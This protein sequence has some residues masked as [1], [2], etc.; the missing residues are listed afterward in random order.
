MSFVVQTDE[1]VF[2]KITEKTERSI[3]LT[4]C[5]HGDLVDVKNSHY[6]SENYLFSLLLEFTEHVEIDNKGIYAPQVF[7]VKL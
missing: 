2:I 5:L 3:I 4:C 7:V 6:I 1:Q